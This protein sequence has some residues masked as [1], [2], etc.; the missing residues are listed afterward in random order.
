MLENLLTQK[1]EPV[2]SLIYK[3]IKH[4][5]VIINLTFNEGRL[6]DTIGNKDPLCPHLFKTNNICNKCA[7]YVGFIGKEPDPL[8]F[9]KHL[10][11]LA[12]SF[13]DSDNIYILAERYYPPDYTLPNKGMSL[14]KYK[15]FKHKFIYTL[16]D[17]VSLSRFSR[18]VRH[19]YIIHF[20][21]DITNK[22]NCSQILSK[23]F[24]LLELFD[25]SDTLFVNP[26]AK[27]LKFYSNHFKY[28]ISN[29]QVLDYILKQTKQ[30]KG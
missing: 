25:H 13:I 16:Y 3:S 11:L 17:K 30:S 9:Y 8:T 23:E 26:S 20:T 27:S 22:W 2:S 7:A 21:N 5:N 10:N 18:D 6:L 28:F 14:T 4:K 24:N 15:D 1:P 29:T 12:N 19:L